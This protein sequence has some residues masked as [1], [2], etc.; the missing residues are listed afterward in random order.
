MPKIF[1]DDRLG[2]LFWRLGI[3]IKLHSEGGAALSRRAQIGGI[4]EDSAKRTVLSS[5]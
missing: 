1:E 4:T 2:Y 3:L 5:P